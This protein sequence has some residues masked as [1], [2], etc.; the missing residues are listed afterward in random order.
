[1]STQPEN[2]LKKR[3]PRTKIKR[4][5]NTTSA[6]YYFTNA[7]QEAI[8]RYQKSESSAVKEQIYVTEILPAFSA[9]VENLINVYGFKVQYES[10]EDLKNE[11]LEFL[12][13]AI[14]K[15][16]EEKGSKAF[17]YFNVVSK[18]LLIVK[19]KQST[20]RTQQYVSLDDATSMSSADL[21]KVENHNFVPS[22]EDI[23]SKE[24]MKVFIVKLLE[25][26][27]SK[28]K[29]ENEKLTVDAIKEINENIDELELLSKRAV[30]LYIRNITH[31]SS[32]Q[33]SLAISS[34]KKNYTEF[35]NQQ[36]NL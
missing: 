23:L 18:N 12:Y 2:K 11:C 1:M 24:D 10:K 27:G 35:K 34:L 32:K 3:R 31:L 30:L 36:E 13:S 8:V 14:P 16:N 33:L 25:E 17:S 29:T 20:K 21:D 4:N 19:S 5:A 22:Y 26:L 28:A 7:T 15:F 9:L 6:S